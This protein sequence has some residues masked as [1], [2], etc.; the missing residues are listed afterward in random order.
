MK[1]QIFGGCHCG[2]VRFSCNL[3]V[4]AHTSRCNCSVCSKSRYWFA[5]VKAE[6]FTLLAGA[7]ALADYQFGAHAIHHRFCRTCGVKTFGEA[8]DPSFGGPFFVAVGCLELAPEVRAR[9]P[10]D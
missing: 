7:N 9:L 5:P 3:D 4:S 2:A 1:Q 10:S 6:D 8:H